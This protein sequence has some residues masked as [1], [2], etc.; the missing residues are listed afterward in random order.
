[1]VHPPEIPEVGQISRE[2]KQAFDHFKEYQPIIA[3]YLWEQFQRNGM[4]EQHLEI[5]NTF[6]GQDIQAG[7]ILGDMNYLEH[8]IE[9]LDGLLQTRD[10]PGGLFAEYLT[11]YKQAVEASLDQRGGPIVDWLNSKIIE[12]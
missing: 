4:K 12:S 9:W 2:Y 1:M 5:A 10:I 7:L 11:L 3:A 8:E 6:L